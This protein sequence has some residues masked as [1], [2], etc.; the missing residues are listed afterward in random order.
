MTDQ[1][2]FWTVFLAALLAGVATKVV[3]LGIDGLV[4][5]RA[6][7]ADIATEIACRRSKCKKK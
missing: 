7:A 2:M 3:S 5:L 6:L 1:S 4:W